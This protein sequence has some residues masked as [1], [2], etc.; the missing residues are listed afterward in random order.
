MRVEEIKVLQTEVDRLQQEDVKFAVKYK[1]NKLNKELKEITEQAETKR[2]ELLNKYGVLP[3]GESQYI[4]ESDENA[5]SFSAEYNAVMNEDIEIT[6]SFSIEDFE[7]V[8]GFYNQI[9]DLI[10]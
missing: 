5:T 6:H 9:F 2:I 10:N 3:E 8:T 4:F 7:N 1:L